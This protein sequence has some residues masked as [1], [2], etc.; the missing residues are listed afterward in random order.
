MGAIRRSHSGSLPPG[1]FATKNA[2]GRKAFEV[3]LLEA[4]LTDVTITKE[5]PAPERSTG[6]IVEIDDLR[7]DFRGFESEDGIQDFNEIFALYLMN[8]G[9]VSISRG[10]RD[11]APKRSLPPT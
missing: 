11:C 10:G 5:L 6:V 2:S 7:R 3:K 8:Y 1:G 9:S 4:D